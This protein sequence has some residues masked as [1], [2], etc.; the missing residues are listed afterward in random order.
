MRKQLGRSLTAVAQWCQEHRHEDVG[1]QQKTLNAKL[2]GHYLL[3]T[4][5]ELSEPKV[6]STGAFA[7]SGGSGSIAAIVEEG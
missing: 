2:Q 7:V 5:D 6:S 1:Q 3:R 4:T